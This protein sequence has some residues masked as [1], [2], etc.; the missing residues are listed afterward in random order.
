MATYK[1]TSDRIDGKKRG[2]LL[3]DHDLVGVNVDALL[4]AGHIEQARGAKPDK[5]TQESE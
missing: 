1:V 2:D 4:S 5:N 3:H